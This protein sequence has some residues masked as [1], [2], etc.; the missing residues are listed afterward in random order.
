MNQDKRIHWKVQN[1]VKS[2]QLKRG[3][4]EVCGTTENVDGHHEDYSKALEVN[5]LCKKDHAQRHKELGYKYKRK[6]SPK[7][8]KIMTH[9]VKVKEEDYKKLRFIAE[10]TR[11]TISGTISHLL[12]TCGMFHETPKPHPLKRE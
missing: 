10:K 7:R 6:E 8:I 5:W 12:D 9:S 11:R 1:A 3:A 4:C 2:G